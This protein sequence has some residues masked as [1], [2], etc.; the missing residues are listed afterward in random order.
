VVCLSVF[1]QSE[2]PPTQSPLPTPPPPLPPPTQT[3]PTDAPQDNQDDGGLPTIKGQEDVPLGDTT[4]QP[5]SS[6]DEG[7]KPTIE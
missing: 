7:Q 4:E 1:L 5:S 2:T 6:E 3:G